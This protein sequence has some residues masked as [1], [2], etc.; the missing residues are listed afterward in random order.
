MYLRYILR[1]EIM[2]RT[3]FFWNFEIFRV[4]SGI[5]LCSDSVRT[6]PIIQNIIKQDPFAIYVGF[7]FIFIGSDSV[8]VFGFG[9]FAEP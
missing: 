3:I 5:H 7:G 6:I 4:L 2:F 8:R 1:I 9:L